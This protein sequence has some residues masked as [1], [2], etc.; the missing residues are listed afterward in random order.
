MSDIQIVS[1]YDAIPALEPVW[2]DRERA[3][4][5]GAGAFEQFDLVLQ[6]AKAIAREGGEPLVASISR[7]GLPMTLLPLRRE[8]IIGSRAA[9]PLVYPLAQYT[10][11]VGWAISPEDMP[12]LCNALSKAGLDM[13]LLRKVR[14]DSGLHDALAV[15]GQSQNAAETALYIDLNAYKTFDAYEASFSNPTR[16]NRRQRRQKLEAARGPLSFEVLFGAEAVGCLRYRARLEARL[17]RQARDVKPGVR[18]RLMGTSSALDGGVGCC[19]RDR[20]SRAG[21]VPARHRGRIPRTRYLRFLPW[22]LRSGS[23]RASAQGG[24]RCCARLRGPSSRAFRAT[25]SSGAGR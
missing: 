19:R 17:A 12:P 21:G 6:A 7:D 4:V 15:H 3:R 8:R 23:W 18:W 25:I 1:G 2:H 20:R 13:L 9:I 10:N 11:A 16:R 14:E 5:G 22:R 24:N